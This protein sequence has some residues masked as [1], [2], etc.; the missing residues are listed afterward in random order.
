MGIIWSL[1]VLVYDLSHLE[2][3]RHNWVLVEHLLHR[4]D[5]VVHLLHGRPT[6]SFKA[7]SVFH[8]PGSKVQFGY[9][10]NCGRV[11]KSAHLLVIHVH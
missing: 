8:I 7:A 9:C 1:Q 6:T 3:V 2:G 4:M 11:F 10:I 5:L